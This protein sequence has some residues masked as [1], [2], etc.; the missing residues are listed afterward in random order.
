ML[1]DQLEQQIARFVPREAVECLPCFFQRRRQGGGI[2]WRFFG[3]PHRPDYPT[4]GAAQGTKPP[5]GRKASSYFHSQFVS[6]Q[7]P[8]A[9]DSNSPM[10]STP[11]SAA[12]LP[13][14]LAWNAT[15]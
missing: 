13:L 4:S 2:D 12:N 10:H 11:F 9:V 8:S 1:G 14:A 15:E 6:F 3:V 7:L 5:I